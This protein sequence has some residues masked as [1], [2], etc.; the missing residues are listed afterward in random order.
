MEKIGLNLPGLLAQF[1]NFGI[2]LFILWRFV[3]PP[4]QRILDERRQRI[5]ESLDAAERMR[6]QAS[7]T[8]KLL[9]QQREE[10]RQQAQQIIAQAQEIARRIEAEARE[11]AQRDADALVTRAKAEIQLER[12]GAIAELRRE[13]A[14][15]TVN[16]A[17]RVINQSLDRQAH[18][19]LIDDVLSSSELGVGAGRS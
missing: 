19:R 16:A 10:G 17:E 6:A 9:E 3:L 11:Q 5:Q 15:I 12:D 14:D 8:E 2:L 1:I 13:F 18:R 4:V 7:E